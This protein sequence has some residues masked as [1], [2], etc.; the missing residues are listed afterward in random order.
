M[1]TEAYNR[2]LAQ[3]KLAVE[4]MDVLDEFELSDV[5]RYLRHQPPSDAIKQR[6][7]LK[8]KRLTSRRSTLAMPF[9]NSKKR[10]MDVLFVFKVMKKFEESFFEEYFP[11]MDP[12]QLPAS[13]RVL[14][15]ANA[16]RF[17]QRCKDYR[18]VCVKQVF[19]RGYG[20]N[21]YSRPIVDSME[22]NND[23]AKHLLGDQCHATG[24]EPFPEFEDAYYDK[25]EY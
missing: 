10:H 9:C 8:Q 16:K 23:R 5:M 14:A 13:V 3:F 18:Q 25:G 21:N 4:N 12:S 6:F 20:I 11:D 2:R 19:H 7:A 1:Q 22:Y 24:Y 17:A 15:R